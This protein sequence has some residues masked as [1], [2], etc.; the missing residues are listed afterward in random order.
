MLDHYLTDEQIESF[1]LKLIEKRDGIINARRLASQD[2]SMEGMKA[3]D[4]VDRATQ[5]EQE[6]GRMALER[7]D[8]K[9]LEEIAFA[10]KNFE[11]FGYC[12]ECG[13]EIG[14]ERLVYNPAFTMCVDCKTIEEK[15][16]R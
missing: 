15:K 3:P 1:R 7:K 4:P 11:D 8:D 2:I 9:T 16:V 12:H 10:L 6:D 5:Q 13:E 14:Y